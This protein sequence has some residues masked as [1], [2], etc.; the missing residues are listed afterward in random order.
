MSVKRVVF[1][2]PGETDWNKHR[3]WQGIVAIPLNVRGIEQAKRL[4]KFVRNVHLDVIYS[5]DL[6]RAKDTAAILSEYTKV[7]FHYDERLRERHMGLW[8]GLTTSEIQDWYKVKYQELLVDPH[9]VPVPG[10]ESRKQVAERVSEC[11]HEILAKG[12]ET[13]GIISHTTATRTLLAELVPG[14][15][16]YDMQFRNISVTTIV[17]ND[18]GTWSIS[19]FDDV[20]HLEGTPSDPFRGRIG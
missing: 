10:G 8:Q 2:R 18:D 16:P 17:A 3:R 9:H 1:I 13:I 7:P 4:A 12:G 11:F 15:K 19:Q 20:T 6:R 5:S 14:S